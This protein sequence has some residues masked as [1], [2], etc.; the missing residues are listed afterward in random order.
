MVCMGDK[1]SS[2]TLIFYSIDPQWWK[3]PLLN[4]VAAAAQFSTFTHVEVAIGEVLNATR[5]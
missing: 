2:I 5:T 4:I 3:E 1:G